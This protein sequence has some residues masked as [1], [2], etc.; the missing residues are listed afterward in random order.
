MNVDV[1]TQRREQERNDWKV[2]KEGEVIVQMNVVR[3]G[4]GRKE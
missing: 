1:Y 4:D 3:S 2:R